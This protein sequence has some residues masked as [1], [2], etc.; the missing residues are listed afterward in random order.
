MSRLRKP[1][2]GKPLTFHG[3]QWATSG[4]MVEFAERK[5]NWRAPVD[6]GGGGATDPACL[7]YWEPD[8]ID[9]W[10]AVG[11]GWEWAGAIVGEDYPGLIPSGWVQPT[12]FPR[13]EVA[14]TT[15]DDAADAFGI[16]IET[17]GANGITLYYQ[18]DGSWGQTIYTPPG[19]GLPPGDYTVAFDMTSLAEGE[20][21]TRIT[22]VL[23]DNDIVRITG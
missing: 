9:G 5:P 17:D 18:A 3:R 6:A 14:F 10:T 1:V 2:A 15:Y 20:A 22:L 7:D 4:A 23:L 16:R 19:N 21:V 11:N 12:P 8:V 13:L